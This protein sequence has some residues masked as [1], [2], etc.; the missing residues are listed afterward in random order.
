MTDRPADAVRP[1]RSHPAAGFRE[2]V[3]QAVEVRTR[4]VLAEIAP[5]G[6][7]TAPLPFM[8]A[9][10]FRETYGRILRTGVVPLLFVTPAMRSLEKAHEWSPGDRIRVFEILTLPDNPI[11]EAWDR[12]WGTLW[13]TRGVALAGQGA[14]GQGDGRDQSKSGMLARLGRLMGGKPA[15]GPP[16]PG[17]TRPAPYPSGDTV[18]FRELIDRHAVT[19]G[20][21]SPEDDDIHALEE[22]IRVP[23]AMLNKAWGEIADMHMREFKPVGV[24]RAE[25]GALTGTLVRWQRSLPPFMG[26]FLLIRAA[27]DLEYCDFPF[28]RQLIHLLC[29]DLDPHE[30][31]LPLL[32]EYQAS[33]PKII[34]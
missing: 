6:A 19:H 9:A 16:Q 34:R 15:A 14:N 8:M 10:S 28:M 27:T 29:D 7:P 20:Y 23:P 12:A 25:K 5:S 31:A 21:R 3:A 33:L 17:A 11:R 18:S 26:E 24:S 1:P 30:R 4:K 22:L 32:T 13:A 2:M